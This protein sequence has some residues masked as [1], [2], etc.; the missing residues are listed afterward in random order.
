MPV[1]VAIDP[2]DVAVVHQS[3]HGNSCHR[4][5]REDFIPLPEWF[6]GGHQEGAT[7]L[8]VAIAQQRNYQ[9]PAPHVG[10]D[11]D[12]QLRLE[13]KLL[14][15]H[16]ELFIVFGLLQQLHQRRSLVEET[17]LLLLNHRLRDDN[18]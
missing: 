9:L 2:D 16:R 14:N 1:A 17:G 10:D 12:H 8:A 7:L 5:A 18:G 15:K 13:V 3:N 6:V 4:S 11:V